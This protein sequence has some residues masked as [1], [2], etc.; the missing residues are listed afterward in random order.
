MAAIYGY[1]VQEQGRREENGGESVQRKRK[2][3]GAGG[4]GKGEGRQI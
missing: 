3:G 1:V 2:I 4:K